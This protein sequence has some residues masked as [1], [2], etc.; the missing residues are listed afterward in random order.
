MKDLDIERRERHAAR[1]AEMGERSFKLGGETF[2]YKAVTSYLVLERIMDV[3][4]LEGSQV[5]RAFET[6]I[7]DMLEE[8]QEEK[9]M[10]VLHSMDDPFTLEDLNELCGWLSEVMVRRPTPASS[11][12]T[13]GDAPIEITST[14]DSSSKLV[15]ASAA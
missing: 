1:E 4:N 3:E 8:G 15:E 12:S 11:P 5:V 7:V 2:T 14:D 6:A 9:M 13:A 10:G